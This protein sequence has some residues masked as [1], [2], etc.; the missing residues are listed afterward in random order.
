ML[1]HTMKPTAS[2]PST[3]EVVVAT[4]DQMR[5]QIRRKGQL[6]GRQAD[7]VALQELRALVGD[8]PHRR[9]LLIEHFGS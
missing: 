4:L 6:K 3:P 2:K 5:A 8:G 7:D 9:D 1:F